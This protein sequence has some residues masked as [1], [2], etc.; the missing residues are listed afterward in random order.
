MPDETDQAYVFTIGGTELQHWT[1]NHRPG[2]GDMTIDRDGSDVYV[3]VSKSD[4]RPV[5]CLKRR[6]RDGAV[7]DLMPYGEAQHV[8]VRN[9]ALPGWAFVTYTGTYEEFAAHPDWA[10]FYQE[11]V[12]LR[13]DGSGEIR[14]IVQTRRV[15]NDYWSEAHATPSPDGSRVIWS[16]N[17][18]QSDAPVA[19]YVAHLAWPAPSVSAMR[20]TTG[21]H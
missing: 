3:G 13:I 7:T 9:T 1:E 10:S 17:W 18:G 14:R 20:S 15:G 4:S 19:D 12:A 8:S 11:V 21:S 6:L 2:H 5:P 16:S